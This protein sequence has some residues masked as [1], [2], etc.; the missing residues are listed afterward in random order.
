MSQ[1]N[2]MDYWYLVAVPTGNLLSEAERIQK[3]LTDSLQ[4]YST[5]ESPPIHITLC[6]LTPVEDD[7]LSKLLASLTQVAEQLA[8]ICVRST[9]FQCFSQSHQSLVLKIDDNPGLFKLQATFQEELTHLGYFVPTPVEQWIFHM[10]VLSQLF[11][12]APLSARDFETI[13]KRI[14][15]REPPLDGLVN[16]VELWRPVLD[17]NERVVGRFPFKAQG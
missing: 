12:K 1:G 15:L 7:R 11:A 6:K 13:C 14:A 17:I 3:I 4:V 8:P 9:N 5:G 2:W 16:S 10:T